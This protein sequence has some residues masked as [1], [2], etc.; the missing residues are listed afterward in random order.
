MDIL[1]FLSGT[2]IY[3]IFAI[4]LI[5]VVLVRKFKK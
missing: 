2:G 1:Q 3:L 5:V 4:A